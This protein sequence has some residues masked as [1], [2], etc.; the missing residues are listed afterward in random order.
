MQD[1][2][3]GDMLETHRALRRRKVVDMLDRV[4]PMRTA[5]RTSMDVPL[6]WITS[7]CLLQERLAIG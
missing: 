3:R 4:P 6:T 2:L 5:E 7:L 1:T